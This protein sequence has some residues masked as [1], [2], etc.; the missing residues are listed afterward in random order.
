MNGLKCKV[1]VIMITIKSLFT[2]LRPSAR[3]DHAV[4]SE[5]RLPF[6]TFINGGP[7]EL[8]IVTNS[9]PNNCVFVNSRK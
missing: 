1:R 3:G 2:I 6:F 5:C 8:T 7:T 4:D 9:Q